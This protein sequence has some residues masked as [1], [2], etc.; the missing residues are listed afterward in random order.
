M[1][2]VSRSTQSKNYVPAP[3]IPSELQERY[4]TILEVLTGLTTVSEASRRLDLS[5]NYFQTMLHKAQAALI[6]S[7][8]LKSAGR[9][10]KSQEQKSIEEENKRL[11]KENHHLRDRVETIDR[12]LGV[13]G[14]LLKGRTVTNPRSSKTKTRSK[15]TE[16]GDMEEP[17]SRARAILDKVDLMRLWKVPL[18]TISIVVGV[19]SATLGRW[20]RRKKH[21]EVVV[22]GRGYSPVDDVRPEVVKNATSLLTEL[23]FMVGADALGR[24]VGL[25]RRRAARI[26]HE[27]L[28]ARENERK[29]KTCR[30]RIASPG[31][32]RGFDGVFVETT[33]GRQVVL[34]SGDAAVP[35]R[36][37]AFVSAHYDE[38]AVARA[39]LTDFERHGAPLALRLD[40]APC[41]RTPKI[42][43]LLREW[44]VVVFHGP[45]HYPRFYGQLERQNREHRALLDRAGIM[46]PM[47]LRLECARMID[48]LN[49]KWP[50]CALDWMT[51]AECWSFRSPHVLDRALF[52]WEVNEELE[53]LLR[54]G[55]N[56]SRSIDDAQRIAV[57]RVL[58]KHQLLSYELGGWC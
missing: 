6:E 9:P 48:A 28:V 10:A 20:L 11:K 39:L 46:D 8:A 34:F 5:R 57:E 51:P 56:N 53:K 2:T 44:G 27:A 29:E 15:S 30:I 58:T 24:A 50:R 3:E 26:K 23:G 35:F 45:A 37:G 1:N 17:E 4:T 13:A 52:Q 18:E 47:R 33:D 7:L 49:V 36:T 55:T 21:G 32:V 40:R 43:G 54:Q 42:R 22:R 41:H 25:P 16:S 38:E 31:V 14:D 12:L 19:P